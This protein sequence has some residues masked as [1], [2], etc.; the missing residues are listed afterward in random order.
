MLK[1]LI[2]FLKEATLR[3]LGRFGYVVIK[4]PRQVVIKVPRE[5]AAASD[6]NSDFESMQKAWAEEAGRGHLRNDD[7][8]SPEDAQA[9][10]E[11][12]EA[13]LGV[14]IQAPGIPVMPLDEVL[15][16]L[17]DYARPLATGKRILVWPFE[18]TGAT[19]HL[20]MEPFYV[21]SVY[22]KQFDE[23]IVVT[24][25]RHSCHR[26]NLEIFDVSMAGMK[27]AFSDDPRIF[28]LSG[29]EI[30]MVERGSVTFLLH[31][32][33]HISRA[34]FFHCM[35][36]GERDFY[37]LLPGQQERGARLFA[38]LGIPDGAKWVVVHAREAGFH[39]RF[40]DSYRC[41]N[42]ESYFDSINFL[43]KRDYFV[44][45]IGDSSMK[46]LPDL[47]PRVLDLPFLDNYDFLLDVYA[48]AKCEFMISSNSGPCMLARAFD[49][50]CLAVN[51]P[52]TFAHIPGERDMIA[53]RRFYSIVPG[54]SPNA[55]SY[56]DLTDQK[57]QYVCSN[58]LFT[59]RRI[60]Y[61][62][63]N[64]REVLPITQ[65]MLSRC[66]QGTTGDTA[67]QDKFMEINLRTHN[68]VF[69][70]PAMQ[71]WRGDWYG[72]AKPGSAVPDAYCEQV[73]GFL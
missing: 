12:G 1:G 72:L 4:V 47:G 53:F 3:T 56:R 61:E 20:C 17:E 2:G 69:S 21:K 51:V 71:R 63:L 60:R 26:S 38:E 58:E 52:L 64:S 5:N 33:A 10:D 28:S 13:F 29:F 11:V 40:F 19:G 46:K 22:G 45:R 73:P 59:E 18:R 30:G 48:L 55:I 24:R 70:S 54:A 14:S 15:N 42:I 65:E 62:L 66:L 25:H 68:Q 6:E 16:L 67:S 43:T 49:R 34:F 7:G 23:I 8:L 35:N 41:T 27:L 36:G 50:S 57:I 31:S 39:P 44:L 37:K 32:Y 9:A